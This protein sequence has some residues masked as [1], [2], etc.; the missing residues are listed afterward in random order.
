MS[1]V[2]RVLA[3][4]IAVALLAVV[5]CTASSSATSDAPTTSAGIVTDQGPPRDGGVLKIGV[6][7][8]TAGWNPR[9]SQWGND[10]AIVGSSVLETLVMLD[11]NAQP[12]PWLAESVTPNQTY[13]AW[14][15]RVRPN[16][17]FHDGE[18]L[19]ANAMKLNLDDIL[20]SPVTNLAYGTMLKGFTVVDDRTVLAQLNQPWAAFPSF[21]AQSGSSMLAPAMMSAPDQGQSH[22]IGTGPF[23]FDSWQRD[24]TFKAT[25]NPSYWRPGEPHLDAIQFKV[26]TDQT[27]QSNALKSGDVDVVFTSSAETSQNLD[28][29][30]QVIREWTS[31][32]NMLI[33]STSPQIGGQPNPAANGH[34]RQA[35]A[36]ATDRQAVA[37]AAGDGVGSPTSPFSADG[38]WGQPDDKN[39]YPT[40][41]LDA[42]KREVAAYQSDTGGSAPQVTVKYASEDRLTAVLQVVQQEW[43]QAG[44]DLR[45]QSME[46]TALISD[47]IAGN[48]QLA[49]LPIYTASDP[50]SYYLFWSSTTAKGPGQLSLNFAQYKS[51]TIDDLLDQARKNPDVAARKANYNEIVRQI[52]AQALNIWLYWTPFTM[53]AKPTVRGLDVI[54]QDPFSDYD[55]KTWYGRLWLAT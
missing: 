20:K 39:G 55:P 36:L 3:T 1:T 26:L 40:F 32:P 18:A 17:K 2:R 44:I 43:K 30:Y 48:F 9:V 19:D 12:Q 42:A 4:S 33:T 5:G 15:I 6:R 45:L 29:G 28:P 35:M 46:A 13:D 41:D 53:I 16:I 38:P 50:D 31:Q 8:E 37:A 11:A 21:L 25:K 24:D 52:N 14:T 27:T 23:V 47:A 34:L 54:K 10:G 7:D 51:P 49:A 22:P